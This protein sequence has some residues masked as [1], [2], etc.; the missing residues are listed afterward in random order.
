MK[1]SVVVPAYNATKYINNTVE[2]IDKEVRKLAKDYEIII[3]DNG[4]V[5]GT[6][7]LVKKLATKN[8]RLVHLVYKNPLGKGGA[9]NEGII[10][11]KN[12]IVA[13]IDQDSATKTE[14]LKPLIDA[15]NNGADISIG[16]RLS[17]GSKIKRSLKRE[18]FSRGYNFLVRLLLGSSVKDHQCG[19][20]AYKRD[21]IIDLI[22]NIKDTQWFWDTEML[23]RAQQKKYKITEI[24]IEWTEAGTSTVKLK[25]DIFGMG[26]KL[27]EFWWDLKKEK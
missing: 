11:A 21:V 24:P 15:I 25:R 18:I 16:S 9:V 7:E 4:S 1:I 20:K 23:V 27:I 22:K 26:K 14:Y 13:V 19:F 2:E 3:V 12:D 8:K 6:P 5:D 17:K 10:H